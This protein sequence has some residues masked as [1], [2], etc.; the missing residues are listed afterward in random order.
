M[1]E[2]LL[3]ASIPLEMS[4]DMLN[5]SLTK[6]KTHFLINDELSEEIEKDLNVKLNILLISLETK[7]DP[8]KIKKF[9]EKFEEFKQTKNLLNPNKQ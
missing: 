2:L 4:M 9:M 7:G 1:F 8:G 3:M 5:E 6:A